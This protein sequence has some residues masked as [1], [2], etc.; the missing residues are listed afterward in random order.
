MDQTLGLAS[1]EQ[2]FKKYLQIALARQRVVT[3]IVSA[4]RTKECRFESRQGVRSLGLN[5]LQ[6]WPLH[7]ICNIVRT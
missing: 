6:W 5:T 1:S 4:N 2:T 7:Y 3:V